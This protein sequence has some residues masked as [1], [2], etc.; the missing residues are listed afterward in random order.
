MMTFYISKPKLISSITGVAVILLFSLDQTSWAAVI[1]CP[2]TPTV[3]NGT[4]G[5]DIMFA[6]LSG[7]FM[8]GLAGNDYILASGTNPNYIWGDD[9]NDILFGAVGNDRLEGGR[10]NDK[11]DGYSGDDT[12]LDMPYIEGSLVNND[13]LISGGPGN[14]YILSGEGLDRIYGGSG[15]DQI[16]PS[17]GN[18][19]DFSYDFIDCGPDINDRLAFFFSSDGETA[20]NCEYVQDMDR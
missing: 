12:I 16:Y 9:G 7:S 2:P 3:C 14:D 17:A 6:S 4:S 8:H 11:Y 10:G 18:S 20:M 1:N 5:D 19:R 13:D 15:N